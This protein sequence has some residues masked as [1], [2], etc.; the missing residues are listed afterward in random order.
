LN[1]PNIITLGRLLIVPVIIVLM[2]DSR[3]GL[4]FLL[5]AVAGLSDGI[6]GFIA[7]RFNQA[8]RLGAYLDPIADK[9]LLVSIYI[10]LGYKDHIEIWLVILIVSRDLL[11][12][13]AVVLSYLI[14]HPIDISPLMISKANTVAQITFAGIVLAILSQEQISGAKVVFSSL[15]YVVAVTTVLSGALYLKGW[16]LSVAL[17]ESS[18]SAD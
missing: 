10:A 3:Y 1:I 4:S 13:G 6:D 11:I 15:S 17:W 7:K 14:D 18:D 2:L 5:F 8:T 12:I 9:A 16:I